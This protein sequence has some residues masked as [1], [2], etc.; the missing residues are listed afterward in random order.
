MISVVNYAQ[1][2]GDFLGLPRFGFNRRFDFLCMQVEK[3]LC[4]A[5]YL[6]QVGFK[7]DVASFLLHNYKC[8]ILIIFIKEQ[9]WPLRTFCQNQAKARIKK[10]TTK[11]WTYVQ[12]IQ[13][14]SK[15]IINLVYYT[16][17]Q[18]RNRLTSRFS[19]LKT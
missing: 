7:I 6:R 12:M 15:K 14:L 19:V 10:K 1:V 17:R 16:S 18:P 3:K 11:F 13:S 5:V 9:H 2:P 4:Y 8:N